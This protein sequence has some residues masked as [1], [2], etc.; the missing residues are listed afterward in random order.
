MK[1]MKIGLLNKG[2]LTNC[3]LSLGRC[4]NPYECFLIPERIAWRGRGGLLVCLSGEGSWVPAHQADFTGQNT[5]KS[6]KVVRG[7]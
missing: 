2:N 4:E 5:P 6:C 1:A 3:L 7:C